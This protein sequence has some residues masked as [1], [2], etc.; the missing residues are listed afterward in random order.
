[1]LVA[2][3]GGG[4]A[5]RRVWRISWA[6]ASCS[7]CNCCNAVSWAGES[8]VC[9]WVMRVSVMDTAPPGRGPKLRLVV[10]VVVEVCARML[11]RLA[12]C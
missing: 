1:M 6:C 2:V 4:P 8:T 3:E 12:A 10:S 11:T 9:A 7:R 5:F